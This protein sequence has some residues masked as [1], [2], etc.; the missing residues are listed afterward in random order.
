MWHGT[1][2]LAGL[3][4]NISW[5]KLQVDSGSIY[6][7]YTIITYLCFVYNLDPPTAHH[8]CAEPDF[9]ET[10][11]QWFGSTEEMVLKRPWFQAYEVEHELVP[12]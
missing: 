2:N 4:P 11:Q 10:R 12:W 1:S 6:K 9:L 7:E 3:V 8:H 5:C